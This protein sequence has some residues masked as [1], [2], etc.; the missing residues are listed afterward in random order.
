MI[1]LI[2]SGHGGAV[3]INGVKYYLTKGKRSP[4]VPPGIF[5]G[6]FNRDISRR[7]VY[8]INIETD[9]QAINLTPGPINIPLKSRVKY[10][11]ELMD[12]V[13]ELVIWLSIHA[14]ASGKN[15]W[16]DASGPRVFCHPGSIEGR[17]IADKLGWP[18]KTSRTLYELRKTKMPSVLLECGFMTNRSEAEIM[19]SEPG[20]KKISDDIFL[21]LFS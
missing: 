1:Y 2:N 3:E 21:S 7:L 12:E 14:N 4:E 9:H 16:S 13:S 20:R 17:S 5:E 15:G 6:E 10:A 11:N 18:V 8:R 19:A